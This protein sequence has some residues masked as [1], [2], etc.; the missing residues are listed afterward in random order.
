MQLCE[1]GVQAVTIPDR[2]KE[3]SHR[4]GAGFSI[5]RA[6]AD[7]SAGPPGH[8]SHSS[9]GFSGLWCPVIAGVGAGY[10]AKTWGWDG[11]TRAES[12]TSLSPCLPDELVDW[13][14]EPFS[15]VY[16]VYTNNFMLLCPVLWWQF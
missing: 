9:I 4:G 6:I 15:I 8:R 13:W 16:V 12:C 3:P 11:A 14:L 5:Q 2:Q 1:G 10:S 7:Y